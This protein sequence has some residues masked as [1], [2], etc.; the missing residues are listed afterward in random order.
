MQGPTTS[1]EKPRTTIVSIHELKTHCAACSMRELCLPMG[2]SHDDL[3]EIDAVVT[4]RRRVRKGETVYR[5]GQTASELY[6]I[7]MG[8]LKTTVLAEDGR[9]QVAGYHLAGD[10]IGLD[11]LGLGQHIGDA[12]ALEDSEVCVMRFDE[13]ETLSARLPALQ[14]NL[15]RLLG[16]EVA[17]D[18]AVMLMLGS[19]RAEERV[20]AF[21]LN[22]AERYRSRGYSSTEFNLRMTRE[23]IGSFLGLKLETVSRLFSRMQEE[24]LIAVQGRSIKLLDTVALRQLAGQRA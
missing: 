5:A 4:S 12:V 9:E 22:I 24:G 3:V 10:L 21:L 20:A 6:A 7:R 18:H 8:T 23:E 13:L 16:R 2:L 1:A 17:R 19:M 14:Q 11:G 15:H